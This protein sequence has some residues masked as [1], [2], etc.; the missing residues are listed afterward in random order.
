MA[1]S[2]R[3]H[4]I[5]AATITAVLAFAFDRSLLTPL[6]DLR[7]RMNVAKE[8]AL[9][10]MENAS[11]LFA[12]AKRMNRTWKKM[13]SGG[14]KGDVGQAESTLLH[15]LREW[16]QDSEVTLS[17]VKPERVPQ[18]GPLHLVTIHAV[19]SGPMRSMA[20][21]LWLI[22]TAELPLKVEEIEL[23][24]RKEGTDDLSFQMRLSAVYVA[25]NLEGTASQPRIAQSEGEDR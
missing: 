2:R 24:S 18:E 10:R 3:E 16:S 23:G 8:D 21:F 5:I 7:G 19:G 11:L 15:A 17:S 12:Q 4:Y 22:E 6:L 13:L 9:R 14:L 25:D 20:R 1:F